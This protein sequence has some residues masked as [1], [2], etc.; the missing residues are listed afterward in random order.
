VKP[1]IQGIEVALIEA[2]SLQDARCLEALAGLRINLQCRV[3]QEMSIAPGWVINGYIRGSPKARW[4]GPLP[5]KKS[6]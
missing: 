4:R 1:L 3:A 2:V 5:A 6:I